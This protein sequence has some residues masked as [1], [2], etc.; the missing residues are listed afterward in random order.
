M[1]PFTKQFDV[2]VLKDNHAIGFA[3]LVY[4]E[5]IDRKLDVR[6][7][8]VGKEV[9]SAATS[10]SSPDAINDIRR[11]PLADAQYH[12]INLPIDVQNALQ[13]LMGALQL[14]YASVDFVVSKQGE[15]YFLELNATGAFL[16][17][18]ELSG[19]PIVSNIANY[20]ASRV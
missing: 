18:Q 9:F 13:R 7:V 12:A 8:V 2:S 5:F 15:W 14:E 3:P 6:S 17:V 20:L 4:Q 16:W 10:T 19:L 11:V 1:Q